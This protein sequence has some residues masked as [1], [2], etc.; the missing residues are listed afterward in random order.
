M[1]KRAFLCFL[2]V[3]AEALWVWL[4]TQ[5]MA[6][7]SIAELC[8]CCCCCNTVHDHRGADCTGCHC[9][10]PAANVFLTHINPQ[11]M[12][13][14][15]LALFLFFFL[16][17]LVFSFI[18]EVKDMW[19]VFLP[20]AITCIQS[21]AVLHTLHITCDHKEKKMFSQCSQKKPS[22]LGFIQ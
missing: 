5:G 9:K 4:H 11:V 13:Y 12:G 21:V 14:Q 7:S 15:L 3:P 20:S 18:R 17:I 8:V 6:I 16:H 10:S 19:K 2:P 1:W 22:T